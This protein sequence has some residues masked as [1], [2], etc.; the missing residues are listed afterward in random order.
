MQLKPALSMWISVLSLTAVLLVGC[1][2]APQQQARGLQKVGIF[3]VKS[4]PYTL[5]RELPGRTVSFR[6]AEVRPQVDGIILK[7]LFKEG[8]EVKEGEPLYE[9]D[10]AIYKANVQSAWAAVVSAQALEKRYKQLVQTKAVSQQQYDDAKASLLQAQANLTTAKV[11][12][13]YTKV[14][15]PLTGRISR[16]LVT[17]GAL[18][19]SGQ[20][21]ALTTIN[22]LDPIY[23]DIVRP[24]KD[25]L[26]MRQELAAGILEK[27]GENAAKTELKLEDGSSYA[28]AGRLEFSEVSVNESTGSVTLRAIFPNPDKTLLPGMFVQ[29]SLK[30]GVKQDAILVPQLAVTRNIKG[31][32]TAMVLDKDNKVEQRVLQV[33][34]VADYNKWLVNS[35][36]KEGDR[37]IISGLQKIQPGMQV[38]PIEETKI[39]ATTTTADG[40]K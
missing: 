34:H 1:D 33:A 12:L 36:L 20:A 16:S 4:Q 11:K 35:G 3:T 27:V 37:V 18:V 10:P 23:V 15:A 8:G 19:T 14:L 28:H 40:N 5:T 39:Q 9:I 24:S 7:R 26:T 2:K 13:Q 32:A 17:E 38:D 25:I 30:E 29:A 21:S 6:V 22:Q 31:E